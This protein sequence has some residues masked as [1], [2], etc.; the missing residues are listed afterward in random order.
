[1][2][3]ECPQRQ[4][5]VKAKK[6]ATLLRNAPMVVVHTGAGLSTAAGERVS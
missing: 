3:I 5:R 4:V 2:E 1:M 6:L